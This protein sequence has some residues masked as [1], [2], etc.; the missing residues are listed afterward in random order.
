MKSIFFLFLFFSFLS[1]CITDN[2][3]N[4]KNINSDSNQLFPPK[5]LNSFESSPDFHFIFTKNNI[6]SYI[7]SQIKD[8]V[9][10][11]PLVNKNGFDI[12]INLNGSLFNKTQPMIKMFYEIPKSSFHIKQPV[13]VKLLAKYMNDPDIR[14]KWDTSMKSYKIIER[15]NDE[16]YLLHYVYKSPMVF[17]SERDIVHKRFDFLEGGDEVYYDFSSSVND[18]ILAPDK[19]VMRI[20]DYCSL[21]KMFDNGDKIK[22]ISITQVDTKFNVPPNLLK[23]QLPIKYKEWYDALVKEINNSENE[24]ENEKKEKDL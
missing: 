16:V 24:N 5:Y 18:D 12:Y 2:S 13:T 22:I 19:D 17:V 11:T 23:Y 1:L 20:I 9:T 10:F 8:N 15:Q 7:E 4:N 3:N 14:I 6:L 21:Y